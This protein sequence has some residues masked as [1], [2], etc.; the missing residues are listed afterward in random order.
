MCEEV[1]SAFA[2]DV[3]LQRTDYDKLIVA[4]EVTRFTIDAIATFEKPLSSNFTKANL[5]GD[6]VR[7]LKLFR[8]KVGNE[9][10]LLPPLVYRRA[11]EIVWGGQ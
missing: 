1:R 2:L 10:S 4:C 9:R 5:H 11:M 8:S 7:E 6:I 3:P